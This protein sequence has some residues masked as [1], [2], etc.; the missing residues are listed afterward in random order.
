M[1]TKAKEI[2][3]S[4][5]RVDGSQ[6]IKAGCPGLSFCGAG[7]KLDIFKLRAAALLDLSRRSWP[8]LQEQPSLGWTVPALSQ[9]VGFQSGFW[10]AVQVSDLWHF[11]RCFA[12]DSLHMTHTKQNTQLPTEEQNMR[13]VKPQ[14]QSKSHTNTYR[15]EFIRSL[16]TAGLEGRTEWLQLL[17]SKS[18]DRSPGA[19]TNS[20]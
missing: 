6:S 13:V 20:S 11:I 8:R 5:G 16:V 10:A 1:P 17:C 19:Q 18:Q 7:Q 2:F 12:Y 14:K 3:I 9:Q 4:A 15:T